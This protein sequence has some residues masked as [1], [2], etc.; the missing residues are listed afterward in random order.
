MPCLN[1]CNIITALLCIVSEIFFALWET[2][3]T[4]LDYLTGATRLLC[5][6]RLV[7]SIVFEVLTTVVMAG[8]T[9]CLSTYFMLM[10]RNEDEIANC[11][12]QEDICTL[13]RCT[14]I[15]SILSRSDPCCCCGDHRLPFVGD[16]SSPLVDCCK[17]PDVF[18]AYE[19]GQNMDVGLTGMD[20][21]CF[22]NCG[23]GHDSMTLHPRRRCALSSFRNM[24]EKCIQQND[25]I[26]GVNFEY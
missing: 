21:Y 24:K 8:V 19:Y 1:S 12:F 23:H 4:I 17:F 7:V 26:R 22:E 25:D 6:L 11:S 2:M 20:M 13:L 9:L 16:S 5:W 15:R 3:E 10:E 14:D 18:D